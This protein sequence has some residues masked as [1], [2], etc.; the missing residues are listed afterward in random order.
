MKKRREKEK[1]QEIERERDK[2]KTYF[3]ETAV[4]LFLSCILVMNLQ[5]LYSFSI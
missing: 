4:D 2:K 3:I 5:P 1:P